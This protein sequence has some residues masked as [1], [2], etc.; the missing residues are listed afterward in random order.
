MEALNQDVR[1]RFYL[2]R[3]TSYRGD[4]VIIS[5]PVLKKSS[6]SYGIEPS[7]VSGKFSK[8]KVNDKDRQTSSI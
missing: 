3:N 1:P 5:L 6:E 8:G 2:R 7:S 4:R